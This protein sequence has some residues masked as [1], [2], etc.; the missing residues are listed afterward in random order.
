MFASPQ[1]SQGMS[2]NEF[3]S[4]DYDVMTP[5]GKTI[6]ELYL[7][8]RGL[9]TDSN[10]WWISV[11]ANWSLLGIYFLVSWLCLKYVEH[12]PVFNID[13]TK[14]GGD[15]KTGMVSTPQVGCSSAGAIHH[16][17]F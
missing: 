17:Q 1:S 4:P 15:E 16:S 8:N 9:Y 2:S 11:A 7:E 6:G 3:H 5:S 13:S 10:W 14:E 12:A